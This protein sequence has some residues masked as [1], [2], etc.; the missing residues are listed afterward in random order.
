MANN[1]NLAHDAIKKIKSGSGKLMNVDT[2]RECAQNLFKEISTVED[3]F[4]YCASLNYLNAFVKRDT[5][6]TEIILTEEVPG[7]YVRH[8]YSFKRYVNVA[9]IRLMLD[10]FKNCSFVCEKG[11]E[12]VMINVCGVQFSFH[13]VKIYDKTKQLMNE[14]I[15]KHK[16]QKEST[17]LPEKWRGLRL[18][19]IAGEV[20]RFAKELENLTNKKFNPKETEKEM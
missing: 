18:Q 6:M 1:I 4:L 16:N 19:P 3:L 5:S 20:Y 11:G 13:N 8:G 7:G 2:A 10:K 15:K 12:L 17:F 9:L 14:E